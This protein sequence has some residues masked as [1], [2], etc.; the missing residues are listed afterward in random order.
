MAEKHNRDNNRWKPD[1]WKIGNGAVLEF[2]GKIRVN[3]GK[4]KNC[5]D[6]D[7]KKQEK[8]ENVP[9]N[10]KRTIDATAA[11]GEKI[12]NRSSYARKNIEISAFKCH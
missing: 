5:G 9:N 6:D 3:R 1:V 11:K 8:R 10:Q 12:N 2:E 7:V 4:C